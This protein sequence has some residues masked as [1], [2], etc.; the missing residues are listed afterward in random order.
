MPMLSLKFPKNRLVVPAPPRIRMRA[1]SEDQSD[2]FL[3]RL[4]KY[5]P[6]EV[7][8][9]YMLLMGMVEAMDRS[10]PMKIFT[11]WLIFGAL[12]IATPYYLY[13]GGQ[14]T[15][16]QMPQLLISTLCFVL[17]AYALGGPFKMGKPPA[18]NL[19]YQSSVASVIAG[20][21]SLFLARIELREAPNLIT[22][23]SDPS[24]TSD[25]EAHDRDLATPAG[26]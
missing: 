4:I 14:P 12:T 20:I 16:A 10:N 23:T 19:Y 17:W 1:A 7:V 3:T 24:T 8:T 11:A 18:P 6:T 25:L 22:S 21:A 2:R 9:V 15:R 26:G 5:I 13:K